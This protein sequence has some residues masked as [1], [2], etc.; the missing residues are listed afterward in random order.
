MT[1]LNL[2][3]DGL[4]T[5]VILLGIDV[6]LGIIAALMKKEFMLGKL[7]GFMGKNVLT[8]VFGF[9]VLS[10][11]AQAFPTVATIVSVAYWL[12]ILALIGS[13]LDN[14]AKIGVPIPK[15]LRK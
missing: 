7:A 5:I 8:Y 12:I 1:T 9:A 4:Q 14:L 13:L 15:I 2:A 3:V 6:V 10:A 11:V